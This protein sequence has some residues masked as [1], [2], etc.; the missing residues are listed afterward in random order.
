M[1]EF[2]LP[3][4]LNRLDHQELFREMKTWCDENCN[5]YVGIDLLAMKARILFEEETDAV[6]FKLKWTE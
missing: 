3:Y 2:Y 5:G 6:A 1:I 4:G